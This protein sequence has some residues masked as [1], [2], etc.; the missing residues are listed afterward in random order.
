MWA[1]GTAVHI[2]TAPGAELNAVP[3]PNSDR[4]EVGSGGAGRI[5]LGLRGRGSA[6]SPRPLIPREPEQ[7][8]GPMSPNRQGWVRVG[9]VA[10]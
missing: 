9:A 3:R 5:V 6:W 10:A 1:G 7:L 4:M 2:S 8:P